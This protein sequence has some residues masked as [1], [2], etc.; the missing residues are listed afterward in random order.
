ML[1]ILLALLLPCSGLQMMVVN[2]PLC[3]RKVNILVP[4]APRECAQIRESCLKISSH[5]LKLFPAETYPTRKSI[6]PDNLI[7]SVLGITNYTL[8]HAID[9]EEQHLRETCLKKAFRDLHSVV[10]VLR[11]T[12]TLDVIIHSN[13]IEHSF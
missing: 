4:C 10:S 8:S 3:W 6:C 12:V 13:L 11:E 7:L 1:I 5:I 2:K 9:P